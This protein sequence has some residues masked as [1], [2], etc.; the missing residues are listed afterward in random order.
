MSLVPRHSRLHN[1]FLVLDLL[2]YLLLAL[3]RL[4]SSPLINDHDTNHFIMPIHA[5]EVVVIH[6][7]EESHFLFNV[8]TAISSM[9]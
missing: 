7:A 4:R 5:C 2:Y 6:E 9:L 3:L 1:A 8:Q